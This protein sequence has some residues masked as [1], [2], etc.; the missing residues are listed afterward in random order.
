MTGRFN[1]DEQAPSPTTKIATVICLAMAILI[2][3]FLTIAAFSGKGE[4]PPQAYAI[5]VS[6]SCVIFSISAV[7]G[8][9]AYFVASPPKS[10]IPP[11][12]VPPPVTPS[13]DEV[14]DN[15]TDSDTTHGDEDTNAN[16]NDDDASSPP[17]PAH[18]R[19][20]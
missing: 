2:A 16:A 6:F 8:V 5:I 12:R 4:D 10:K 13:P 3:L 1:S 18:R 15:A 11:R 17:G 19:R 7:V 14:E 20:D 9:I